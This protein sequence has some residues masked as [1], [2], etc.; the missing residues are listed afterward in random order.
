MRS[1]AIQGR[2]TGDIRS[3]VRFVAAID[4][5]QAQKTVRCNG[6]GNAEENFKCSW[7]I[8]SI[9]LWQVMEELLPIP[10]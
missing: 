2:N 6:R 9:S 7:H 8:K 5:T 10:I 4:M 1:S 3:Y